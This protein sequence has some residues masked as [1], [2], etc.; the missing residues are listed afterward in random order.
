M[1]RKYFLKSAIR[2]ARLARLLAKAIDL[3]I[4]ILISIFFGPIGI[5]LGL[6]Y[7]AIADSLQN[8]QSVGKRVIGFAV[9]SMEDGNPCNIKQSFIR[10]LPIIIPL[11]FAI[12]PIWGWFFAAIIGIPL[13]LLEVYLLY[14]LDSG[15]RLGDVMADTTVVTSDKCRISFEKEK[16]PWA[17]P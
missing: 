17:G 11:F 14:T 1:D 2:T 15:H 3:F 13:I 8:G 4:V 6:I 7:I 5:L 12:I 10:N 9:V 16:A